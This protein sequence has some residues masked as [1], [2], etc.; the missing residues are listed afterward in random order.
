MAKSLRSKFK[1][2]MRAIARVKKAPKEAARLDEAV[3]RRDQ[4]D[5]T[6]QSIADKTTSVQAQEAKANQGIETV[7]GNGPACVESDDQPA[8]DEDGRRKVPQLDESE[9]RRFTLCYFRQRKKCSQKKKKSKTQQ[10][11]KKKGI[12]VF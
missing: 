6:P 2:K 11:K 1:R 7:D 3:K 10:G 4:F 8:D 5:S 12:K 9:A